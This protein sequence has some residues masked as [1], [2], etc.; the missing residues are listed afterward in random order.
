MKG[1]RCPDWLGCRCMRAGERRD[2]GKPHRHG[3]R[4]RMAV[5]VRCACGTG[6]TLLA[7]GTVPQV[8]QVAI[9]F[10]E[11]MVLMA[12]QARPAAISCTGAPWPGRPGWVDA[13]NWVFDSRA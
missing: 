1:N 2:A 6:D 9:R 3:R 10:D 8:R 7:E 4:D 12:M 13:S 11:A 5:R